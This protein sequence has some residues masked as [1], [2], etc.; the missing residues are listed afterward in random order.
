MP[1][2]FVVDNN[3]LFRK[4]TVQYLN[5]A[6]F[7]EILTFSSADECLKFIDL[8]PD[9][10]ITELYYGENKINGINLLTRIKALSP[11]TKVIFLSSSGDMER[12]VQ[13]VRLGAVDFIIKSK[14]ALNRLVIRIKQLT[15]Y[16]SEIKRANSVN[17]TLAASLAILILLF[18]SLIY[19][20]TH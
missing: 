18:I 15:I 5:V 11:K 6:D 20:Y 12:A 16:N 8:Q 10:V 1:V 3:K 2:I 7:N 4:L 9:I 17:I 13:S 14:L 19:L